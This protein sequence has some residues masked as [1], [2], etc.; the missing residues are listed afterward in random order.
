MK[1]QILD[2]LKI[3]FGYENLRPGQEQAIEHLLAGR[4]TVVI[5]P[6]GQ[7]KSLCYQLP[8]LLLDGVALVVSPL[9]ALMKDQVD[10]LEKVGIPATF[11]NSS[12]SLDEVNNRL[13]K[14]RSGYYKIIYVAPERF[15]NPFFLESLTQI[16]IS[17]F[18]IDEAHCISQWGHDFRPSYT[19]LA[20]IIEKLNHPPVIALTAT[21]TM[22][23]KEDIVRQ[24]R[25]SDPA[26]VITGF[27]RPNLEL[28]IAR[29]NESQKIDF[30]LEAAAKASG[31]HGIVYAGTRKNVERILEALRD[32]GFNASAYHAGMEPKA[33]DAVQN[34]FVAG[35]T[36]IIVATNA[37][38]MGIDKSNIRFVIH[39]DMP[40][41]LEAY[42]QE[43]GRAGRDGRPSFCLMLYNSRDRYL[44][45]FF[46]QGDNPP[47]EII[48]E[49]YDL[50]LGFNQNNLIIT[51]AEL[52]KQLTDNVPDMA[53]GTALK[54][55]EKEG[56]IARA[57]EKT[58]NAYLKILEPEE[59][60]LAA[61][62]PKAKT[63]LEIFKALNFDFSQELI[64][65]WELNLEE[66][67]QKLN[68]KKDALSRLI[69]KLADLNLAEYNP[70]ARG[71]EIN[72]LKRLNPGEIKLDLSALKAKLDQ[73]Y[74]KLNKIE[75][76]VYTPLCRQ[77]FILSYFGDQKAKPCG[78]CDNC[79]SGGYVQNQEAVKPSFNKVK[80]IKPKNSADTIQFNAKLTQLETLELYQKG[81]SVKEIAEARNLKPATIIDHLCFL[82]EKKLPI[83]LDKLVDKNKQKKIKAAIKKIGPEKLSL[84]REKL[85]GEESDISWEDIK[86]IRSFLRH[87]G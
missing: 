41:T 76:F 10:S 24:L 43:I 13:T 85:G 71:T 57:K 87:G 78:K 82:L 38:G 59:K 61:L 4:S 69:K 46:I 68:C 17:L 3:H 22:E 70:P 27:A 8:A 63:S 39:A 40:G 51:Y 14:I 86:L 67:A 12:L 77:K 15:A 84:I 20:P 35:Q 53:I 74:S 37:F 2:L 47:P 36:K 62:G 5:M 42:Y 58:K 83:D 32:A 9:I 55:L 30:I 29:A 34:S 21:A 1:S 65:G 6:T 72:I 52:G 48:L 81:L 66:V 75:S 44:Q 49:L 7:G 11:I 60:I 23:V 33:R 50:L 26:F 25:L 19:R 73:A 31:E 64:A 80:N 79:A 16:K 54:I 18:A 28:G 56:Y 45:E